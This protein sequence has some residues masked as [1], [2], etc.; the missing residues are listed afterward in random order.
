MFKNMPITRKFPLVVLLLTIITAVSIAFLTVT[1]VR[2]AM[3]T[4]ALK[5]LKAMESVISHE[6][7][8]VADNHSSDLEVMATNYAV[9]E[10]MHKF[11]QAFKMIRLEYG[12]PGEYLQQQFITNNPHPAKERQLLVSTE[13]ETV[14]SDVHTRW[15]DWFRTYAQ[16]RGYTDLLLVDLKGNVVFSVAKN[17]D[18]GANL[19]DEKFQN[20]GLSKVVEMSQKNADD[21][22]TSFSDFLPYEIDEG[23]LAGFMAR[24]IINEYDSHI[25]TLVFRLP[26]DPFVASIGQDTGL[27]EH[28]QAFVIGEDFKLRFSDGVESDHDGHQHETDEHAAAAHHDTKY[29]QNALDGKGV[30]H[31][32][33]HPDGEKVL[34]SYGG[35][36]LYGVKYVMI[37]DV[38]Y[39]GIMSSA[40]H[41]LK[42][43]ILIV[44]ASMLVFLVVVISFIRATV[45][46]LRVLQ[47]SLLKIAQTRDLRL[48]VSTGGQDEI[49]KSTQAVDNILELVENFVR[50]AKTGANQLDDL[51]TDVITGALLHFKFLRDITGDAKA[52]VERG[53]R[54]VQTDYERYAQAPEDNDTSFMYQNS[55]PFVDSSQLVRCGL[56]RSDEEYLRHL[57]TTIGSVE[58]SSTT[59]RILHPMEDSLLHSDR[60]NI[61]EV[62]NTLR[63][64][65][66]VN[67]NTGKEAK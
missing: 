19:N 42:N 22:E 29:M 57:S 46:P 53:D 43:I 28:I 55:V 14:Y 51:A 54:F 45:N 17:L 37:W 34:E 62:Q 49:G 4:E 1:Q 48:R 44:S 64:L 8:L 24:P 16:K 11:E 32:T 21:S 13:D 38:P 66:L 7:H 61:Y 39:A 20:T 60:S 56:I 67:S 52:E 18:F 27:G 2:Q 9:I 5:K 63:F 3:E 59:K 31:I 65:D 23:A 33:A 40:S 58:D 41:L 50:N 15:Q 6:F 36:E 12:N 26:V 30:T 35:M 47:N 25:G 10:A